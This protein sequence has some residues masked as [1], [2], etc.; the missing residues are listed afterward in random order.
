MAFWGGLVI[1]IMIMIVT[2]I[3]ST[4]AADLPEFAEEAAR[5]LAQE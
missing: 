4:P 5:A 2:V 1:T 3:V